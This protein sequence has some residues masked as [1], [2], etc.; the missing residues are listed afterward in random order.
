MKVC[1]EK[2]WPRGVKSSAIA[3]YHRLRNELSVHDGYVI[4]G[5]HRV[6]IPEKL[7]SKFIQLAHKAKAER[8][9]LVAWHGLS[10]EKCHQILF[11][12]PPA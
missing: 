3:P 7:Q 2:G 12:L 8:L 4:R 5:T 6:I 10:S 11:H 9:V 1:I